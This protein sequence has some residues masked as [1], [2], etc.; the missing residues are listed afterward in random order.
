[1]RARHFCVGLLLGRFL[2]VAAALTGARLGLVLRGHELPVA[3]GHRRLLGDV[4][5]SID[6]STGIV[7][8]SRSN[9]E[10]SASGNFMV[11]CVNRGKT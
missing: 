4:G 7:Q 1:M 8:L 6:A 5:F 2:F 3:V 11:E 9:K 10:V